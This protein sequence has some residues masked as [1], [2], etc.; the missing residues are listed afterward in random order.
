MKT[1][2]WYS[3]ALLLALARPA[4]ATLFLAWEE[5][6]RGTYTGQDDVV[7]EIRSLGGSVRK[8]LAD[9]RG[10]RV[11]LFLQAEAVHNLSEALLHQAY[12]EWKGPMGRWNVALGRVPLPWG[13][14]TDWS[15][16]RM[17]YASPYEPTRTLSSDNGLLLRGTLGLWDYGA[18]LTQGYGME[19]IEDFPGPGNATF[20]LGLTPGLDEAFTLGLS[21]TAGKIYAS[22]DGHGMGETVEERRKAVAL[23]ATW[24]VG[25][26]TLRFEGGARRT[27]SRWLGTAFAAADYAWLPRVTLQFAGHVYEHAESHVFGRAYAG[28]SVPLP[29]VTIRG[30]YEHAHTHEDEHRLVVQLYRY[31]GAVR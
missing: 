31:W 14:L 13:L 11:I 20:R 18:A 30:G 2:K 9:R 5:D 7:G 6:L 3:L 24:H 27:S 10:D 16:D 21:A 4:P 29:T 28:V 22:E 8:V 19:T 25:R 23:D 26:G 12:G 15:P 1:A 17:P